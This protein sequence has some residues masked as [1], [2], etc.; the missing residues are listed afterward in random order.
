MVTTCLTNAIF[1]LVFIIQVIFIYEFIY[2]FKDFSKIMGGW[3][4]D[5][6]AGE[7]KNKDKLSLSLV[8][9]VALAE[10]GKS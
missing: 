2:I 3:W 9:A 4:A 5:G 8:S 7:M 1:G 6:A 10:L